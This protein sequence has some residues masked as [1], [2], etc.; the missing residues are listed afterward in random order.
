MFFSQAGMSRLRLLPLSKLLH[1]G[2]MILLT[3]S[4]PLLVGKVGKA[5]GWGMTRVL[6]SALFPR[7]TPF[8]LI[9]V[10][11]H[12]GNLT[13]ALGLTWLSKFRGQLG[14]VSVIFLPT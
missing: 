7:H 6:L 13:K 9:T 2:L 11:S 4:P 12:K 14:R 1:F 8:T 5:V 3:Q 10:F